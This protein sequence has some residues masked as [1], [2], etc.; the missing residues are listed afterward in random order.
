MTSRWINFRKQLAI[1]GPSCFWRLLVLWNVKCM[2]RFDE[3]ILSKSSLKSALLLP[4]ALGPHPRSIWPL[5]SSN[6]LSGPPLFTKFSA[7]MQHTLKNFTIPQHFY[8]VTPLWIGTPCCPPSCSR[9]PWACPAHS[10][11]SSWRAGCSGWSAYQG[12]RR[13]RRIWTQIQYLVLLSL[14][15]WMDTHI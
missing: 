6:M 15:I 14:L 5:K 12:P 3:Y 13:S 1:S 4:K 10:P 8:T 7:F 2:Y 9:R 11:P